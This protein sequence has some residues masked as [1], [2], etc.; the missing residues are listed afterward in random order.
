MFYRRKVLLSLLDALDR[1]VPR[2]DLQKYAFLVSQEQESPSYS[3]VPYRFGP[4][5][6]S[7]EADKRTL[8]N[9][10]V[11][12]DHNK[13]VLTRPVGY[14][15]ELR[16]A[17]R[18]AI[19]SVVEFSNQVQGDDLLLYVYQ[20]YPYYAINSE[21]LDDVLDGDERKRVDSARPKQRPPALL[22]IGYE[23]KSLEQFLNLLIKH[24]VSV[25]CDV[26]GNPQSR[27]YG[28]SKRTLE[29]TSR[30]VGI[31]YEHKPELG[32][33]YGKRRHLRSPDDYD[34]LFRDY[35]ASTLV[36]MQESVD[37]IAQL[38]HEQQRVALTCF[39]ADPKEC[40]RSQVANALLTRSDFPY[41]VTH[42]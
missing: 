14:L 1:P 42:L 22:T 5:S 9:K 7:A 36:N 34:Q 20:S 37:S 25:L 6:F 16:P 26:R 4:Y 41:E 11:L 23:Q 31:A 30:S 17:D 15:D 2:T 10:G 29:M 8:V 39:E 24:S 38:V 3:F 13:W 33:D 40:H 35:W 27:K 32:I 19:R 12:R 18:D 21:I 28:F